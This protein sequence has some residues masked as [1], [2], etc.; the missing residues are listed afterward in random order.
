MTSS[1]ESLSDDEMSVLVQD[2]VDSISHS[3]LAR[4]ADEMDSALRD[5]RGD[6]TGFRRRLNKRWKTPLNLLELFIELAYDAGSNFNTN[7]RPRAAIADDF[8]FEALTR[9]HARACQIASEV[10]VLLRHGFADGAH[11]RWRSVHEIAIV[12][13]MIREHGNALAERYLLHDTIQR[14]KLACT[15]QEYHERIGDDPVPQED[16]QRLKAERDELR[17]RFGRSFLGD[18]GWA[19]EAIGNPRPT[20]RDLELHAGIDHMRPY[21]RMASDNVHANSHASLYRLGLGTDEL[22]GGTLL[23]GPSNMGLADPGHATAL[24]LSQ[25]TINLICRK[26]GLSST[27]LA[28]VLLKMQDR[29]GS[30]FLRVHR[31]IL[32][33]A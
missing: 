2:F 7:F 1:I 21:Y 4:L 14:Y 31:E 24:T 27:A 15:H 10:L 33:S 23:A 8:A 30:E 16:I 29:V 5:S 6:L 20:I 22:V 17:D 25:I 13:Y 12:S 19:A 18:Y 26:S 9:L 3:L 32:D 11:A 28:S